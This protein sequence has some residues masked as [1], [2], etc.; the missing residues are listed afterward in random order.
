MLIVGVP[1]V[2][3]LILPKNQVVLVIAAVTI[4]IAAFFLRLRSG[5]RQ[6]AENN[7]SHTVKTMQ[8]GAFYFGAM[9][10]IFLDCMLIASHS[11]PPGAMF[12]TS[13]DQLVWGC[14]AAFYLAMM[15]V[16]MYPGRIVEIAADE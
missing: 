15:V 16:A 6:I 9:T 10:L 3:E 4:P 13:T 5:G 11:V 1:Y 2:I 14:L 8:C 12:A 7:C